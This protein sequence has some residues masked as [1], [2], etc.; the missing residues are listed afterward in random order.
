MKKRMVILL[1]L[2]L[3]AMAL[4]GCGCRHKNTHLENVLEA[5]CL[6]EGYSG[7]EVCD[8]C[9]EIVKKGSVIPVGE[10]TLELRNVVKAT[11]TTDGFS[12]D[13]WC[14]VCKKW[15]EWGQTIP[16]LG[17]DWSEIR[18]LS[19]ATCED[20]GYK[21]RVCSRCQEEEIAGYLPMLDHEWEEKLIKEPTCTE[22]GLKGYV[23]RNCGETDEVEIIPR[24][25]HSYEEDICTVCGWHRAG[26]YEN[27]ELVYDWQTLLDKRLIQVDDNNQVTKLSS[28]LTGTLVI[29]EDYTLCLE[30]QFVDGMTGYVP[31][32]PVNITGLW[33]PVTWDEFNLKHDDH[34]FSNLEKLRYARIFGPVEVLPVSAFSGCT[35]LEEVDL[36]STLTAVPAG[37]FW[38]CSSLRSIK[39]PDAVTALEDKAFWQC[40]ALEE[41][42]MEGATDI[43]DHVFERC[44]SLAS[45][46]LSRDLKYI[47]IDA[48]A[49]CSA[50]E[51][52]DFPEGLKHIDIEAFYKSGLTRVV[53]PSS[54]SYIDNRAFAECPELKS[55]ELHG[56]FN[57]ESAYDTRNAIFAKCPKLDTVTLGD[58]VTCIFRSMFAGCSALSELA[59][60]EGVTYFEWGAVSGTGVKDLVFPASLTEYWAT[61]ITTVYDPNSVHV[62]RMDFSAC[63]QLTELTTAIS[64]DELIL[65][66]NLTTIGWRVQT[67]KLVLPDKL[68]YIKGNTT[69][70]TRELVWPVSLVNA[71]KLSCEGLEQI[72]YRG[73]EAKWKQ[74]QL[75]DALK[76]VPVTFNY[77]D[78]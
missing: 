1:A 31:T 9:G 60:P 11:C 48:F 42:W 54:A 17:H 76:G 12:G 39:L 28:R 2:A 4:A 6:Q 65:P 19:E 66:K 13:Q 29:E 36:P 78:E 51:A 77:T 75:S 14:T 33:T 70:Y 52:V 62:D 25:S 8:E 55:V 15:I 74:V 34:I 35:A 47:G 49:E 37:C 53:L 68:Q 22:T 73:S 20:E 50:L 40:T 43:E 23:C 21:G 69:F 5:T 44:S 24:L 41:A 3:I 63:D 61:S 64:A 18:L 56:G 45:I 38:N 16:A 72:L 46:H 59:I 26:E 30:R 58:G 7:N 27:D 32:T 71:E 67:P 57:S 10:H